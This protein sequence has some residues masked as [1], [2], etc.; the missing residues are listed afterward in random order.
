MYYWLLYFQRLACF[1]S[2]W[3]KSCTHLQPT[4][5]E[6]PLHK[7]THLSAATQ[8]QIG[9]S[10]VL[11]SREIC[12][13]LVKPIWNHTFAS[14]AWCRREPGAEWEKLLRQLSR[15][16]L[17]LWQGRQGSFLGNSEKIF[18]FFP[19]PLW[20]GQRWLLHLE[21]FERLIPTLLTLSQ[22]PLVHQNLL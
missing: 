7:H 16:Q 5:L 21:E 6:F 22:L 4:K 19:S 10:E 8:K 13:S 18:L 11:H 9:Y 3:V 15:W 1:L 12:D 20:L 14:T 17:G 2:V